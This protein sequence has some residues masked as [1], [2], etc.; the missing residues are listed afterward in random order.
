MA[1]EALVAVGLAFGE[2]RIGEQRGGDRLERQ[3]DAELLHHVGFGRI[4]EID[5]D[6][7]GAEHH[8][9]AEVADLRH[10]AEH[11]RVAALGHDRQLAAGLVGPHADAEEAEPKPVADRLALLEVTGRFG[12]GLVEVLERR[13]RQLELARGLEA[14]GAVG[15]GQRDDLAVLLDRP[16]AELGQAEQK[17]ADAARLVPRRRAMIVAAIDELLV[18][19]ADAPIGARLLAAREDRRADRRGPRRAGLAFVRACVIGAISGAE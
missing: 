3:A 11:D 5:L 10:V 17:V 7:A 16:P 9:E 1:A 4:I 13:A 2:R 8:V 6:G 19:G 18:L 12:T 15:A 14:D